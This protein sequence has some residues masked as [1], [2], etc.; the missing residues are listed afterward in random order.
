[1]GFDP[2]STQPSA[3]DVIGNPAYPGGTSSGGSVW[4]EY[5][6]KEFNNGLNLVY[7]F[8]QGGA[9]VDKS[10]IDY[11]NDDLVAQAQKFYHNYAQ[12]SSRVYTSDDSIF[13]FWFGQNDIH[14]RYNNSDFDSIYDEEMTTYFDMAESLYKD[15]A[16]N[17]IWLSLGG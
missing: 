10:V 5:L 13:L 9:V 15:G 11:G 17:Y 7:D 4:V 3:D 1:M 16:R 2:T 6:A 8:A 14:Q 12:A